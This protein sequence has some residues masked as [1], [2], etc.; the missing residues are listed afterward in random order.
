[1]RKQGN[2]HVAASSFKSRNIS[3]HVQIQ[4][5]SPRWVG[6]EER[7]STASTPASGGQQSPAHHGLWLHLWLVI[8]LSIQLASSRD[9]F[10]S[11]RG[12]LVSMFVCTESTGDLLP[13]E[14]VGSVMRKELF[15]LP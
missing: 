6:G 15:N 14:V 13:K 8:I 10:T 1:V 9:I 5:H 3:S 12:N 2:H 11:Q 7:A 4:G